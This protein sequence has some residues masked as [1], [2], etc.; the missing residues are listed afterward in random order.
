MVTGESV[1]VD[2]AP[3]TRWSGRAERRRPA[4]RRVTRVGP[5][6]RW[7]G[8][9][10][11]SAR[12]VHQGT[13]AAARRP[14]LVGLRAGR[15]GARADLRGVGTGRATRGGFTAA[16]AVLVIACPCALGLATPTALLVGTGRAAQLGIVMRGPACWSPPPGRHRPVTRREPHRRPDERAEV[17]AP[18]PRG[19]GPAGGRPGAASEHPVGR[20]V[21]AA[22]PARVASAPGSRA[23]PT[24]PAAASPGPSTAGRSGGPRRPRWRPRRRRRPP[25]GSAVVGEPGRPA[26]PCS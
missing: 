3:A 8:S 26:R 25:P 19:G 15:A 14:G 22:A 9:P 10:T 16:V 11:W 2:V 17:V 4:G 6:P 21:A 20:A 24:T 18:G 7:P 5:T 13:G 12:P 23:S 1:P